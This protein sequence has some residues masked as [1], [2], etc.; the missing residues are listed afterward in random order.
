MQK[1]VFLYPFMWKKQV[2]EKRNKKKTINMQTY[3]IKLSILFLAK[4]RK[5]SH[6]IL[7]FY[8]EE[9]LIIKFNSFG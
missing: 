5:K 1:H 7:S 8:E 6:Q 2:V 3:T 9:K 4:F